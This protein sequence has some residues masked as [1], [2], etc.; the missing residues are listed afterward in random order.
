MNYARILIGG[1][2]AG[3]VLNIG[4]FLL[5]GVLL[6]KQM[7]EFF[8]KCGMTPPGHSALIILIVLTFVMGIFI[9]YVY[10]A[11]RPRYGPGPKTAICAGLLAWFCVYFYNSGIAFALGFV[12]ANL[13]LIGLVWGFVEYILGALAGAWLYKEA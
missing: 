3:L 12:P 11:I 6:A 8:A 5:N 13:F 4:E 7:E 2:A 1:L 9:V 10:A